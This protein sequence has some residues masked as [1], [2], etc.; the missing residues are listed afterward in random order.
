MLKQRVITG[1]I[2]VAIVLAALLLLPPTVFAVLSL[3]VIVGLGSWEWAALVGYRFMPQR[4]VAMLPTLVLALLLLLMQPPVMPV[5]V[6]GVMVW[7]G[8]LGLLWHY[9][10]HTRFYRD[11]L[12]LLPMLGILVLSIAWYALSHLNALSVGYVLYVIGLVAVADTGAYF[13]GKRF[14]KVKLAPELSPGKTREGAYGALALGTIWAIAGALVLGFSLGQSIAFVV[15]SLIVVIF[16]IAGDL[17]ESMVK[18]EAGVKDSGQLLPGHGGILDR[19]DGLL[20]AL[21][22]FSLGLWWIRSGL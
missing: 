2:L 3:V 1:I 10:Q 7:G 12:W 6:V 11:Y 17:F 20:A 9:R 18:R 19:I 14:G 8:I 22:V 16:S 21:P 15:L 13:T 4:L 5:V